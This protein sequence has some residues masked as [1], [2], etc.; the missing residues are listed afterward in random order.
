MLSRFLLSGGQVPS[1]NLITSFHTILNREISELLFG[2]IAL[3][4]SELFKGKMENVPDI[5]ML[6]EL[7]RKVLDRGKNAKDMKVRKNAGVCLSCMIVFDDRLRTVIKGGD[8]LEFLY[9]L[10]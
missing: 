7:A 10:K 3:V 1:A 9:S 5:S 2:N 4:L 8:G 6:E